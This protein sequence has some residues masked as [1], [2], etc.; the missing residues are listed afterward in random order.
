MMESSATALTP[1]TLEAALITQVTPVPVDQTVT[2]AV[3]KQQI[4][5]II[6]M[7][8]PVLMM[9]IH[10][11]TIAVTDRVLA[12]IP[13]SYILSPYPLIL[14]RWVVLVLMM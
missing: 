11:P 2:T 4:T 10:V 12:P 9:V 8:P 13:I 5:A 7:V 1:V 6:P 3:T 14:L